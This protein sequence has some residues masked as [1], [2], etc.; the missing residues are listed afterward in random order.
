MNDCQINILRTNE[1][2]R[3]DLVKFSRENGK[4]ATKARICKVGILLKKHFKSS[5][6]QWKPICDNIIT[7]SFKIKFRNLNIIQFYTPTECTIEKKIIFIFI[8]KIRIVWFFCDDGHVITLSRTNQS[9]A[10]T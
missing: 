9:T 1:V 6:T 7:A 5:I 8:L 2:K 4:P 10:I 3:P